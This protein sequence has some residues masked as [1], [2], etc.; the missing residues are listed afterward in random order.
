MKKDC[1]ETAGAVR[2]AVQKVCQKLLP[3]YLQPFDY[4][5]LEELPRTVIGKID[6]K[7]LEESCR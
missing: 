6:Y 5:F 4:E 2:T 1:S 3:D 7:A